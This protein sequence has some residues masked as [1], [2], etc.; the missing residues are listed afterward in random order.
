MLNSIFV[1]IKNKKLFTDYGNVNSIGK[2]ATKLSNENTQD[3]ENFMVSTKP[4]Q[5]L[6]DSKSVTSCEYM[7]SGQ[8]TCMF[9]ISYGLQWRRGLR[10]IAVIGNYILR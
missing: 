5:N 1:E 4:D 8:S 10:Y 9:R 7:K 2:L 3:Y 6:T